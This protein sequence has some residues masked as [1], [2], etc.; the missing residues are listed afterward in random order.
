MARTASF[1][2]LS[3]RSDACAVSHAMQELDN[4]LSAMTKAIRVARERRN[5]LSLPSRLPTEILD[6]CFW[7]LTA[8]DKPDWYRG[9]T[10]SSRLGWINVSHVCASWRGVSIGMPTLWANVYCSLGSRWTTEMLSRAKATSLSLRTHGI[11]Q[12]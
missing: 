2:Q 1:F 12:E 11:T 5:A 8:V 9:S 6:R 10:A 3:A 7:F 4:E